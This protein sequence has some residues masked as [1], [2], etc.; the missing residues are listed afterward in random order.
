MN[1][2]IPTIDIPELLQRYQ[3]LLLDAFGVL[4][5]KQGPLP[6]ARALIDRLNAEAKP[7]YILTNS[8]SRLPETMEAHYREQ[9]LAI[10]AGHIISSGMLLQGHYADH[11]LTGARTVV[12]GPEN[13]QEYARRAGAEVCA[14]DR[15]AEAE[16]VVIAD[17][18]G[19][20]F[21]DAMNRTMS[22]IL[23]GIDAGR[24]PHL[25]LCNPDIIYPIARGEYGFT[26]G[27]MAAMMDSILAQRYPDEAFAFLPL[28]KPHPPIYRE[29]IDRI[30]SDKVIM[31]GDQ[32]ATDIK[33]A[34]QAGIDSLLV[35]TGLAMHDI[36][37]RSPYRPTWQIAS[38]ESRPD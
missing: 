8:A 37:T 34:C 29:G 16:V 20:D 3:G 38:L 28:G 4:V 9:G 14:Y 36:L 11:G 30:G 31:V 17:Q 23:R 19:V 18:A 13:A 5:D 24:P 25:I 27:G 1:E 10:D 15:A 35:N 22:L 26:A 7:Y 21:L 12:L 2:P 6:G 32:L 33:G